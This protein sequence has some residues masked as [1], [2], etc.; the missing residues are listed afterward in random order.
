MCCK[1]PKG[2]PGERGPT[3]ESVAAVC[4]AMRNVEVDE[5]FKEM[6]CNFADRVENAVKGFW[7]DYVVQRMVYGLTESC[8]QSQLGGNPVAMMLGLE[9]IRSQMDT[10]GRQYVSNLMAKEIAEIC[11]FSLSN[12]FSIQE[13]A[14]AAAED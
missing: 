12:I 2:E 14:N 6:L 10:D 3:R 13:A 1:C 5:R 7:S 8:T 4:N 9:L 11:D